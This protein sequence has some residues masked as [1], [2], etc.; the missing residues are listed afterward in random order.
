M[1]LFID[2]LIDWVYFALKICYLFVCL[3]ANIFLFWFE[4]LWQHTCKFVLKTLAIYLFIL[5]LYVFIYNVL[6]V[7]LFVN[8][9]HCCNLFPHIDWL[10]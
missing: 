5:K 9:K 8:I 6:F 1:Y 4:F 10:H 3:S 7:C 2:W